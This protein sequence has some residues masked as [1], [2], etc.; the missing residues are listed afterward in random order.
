MTGVNGRV[1]TRLSSRSQMDAMPERTPAAD[2]GNRHAVVMRRVDDRGGLPQPSPTSQ[3]LSSTS[4]LPPSSARCL[5]SDDVNDTR[6]HRTTTER[7]TSPWRIFSNEASTS[8][9]VIFSVTKASRSK[10]P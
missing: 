6:A 2:G 5:W 9:R 8:P 3:T 10:R 7:R 1:G 4:R